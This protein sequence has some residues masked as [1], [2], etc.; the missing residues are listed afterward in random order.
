MTAR[1]EARLG[2]AADLRVCEPAHAAQLHSL[3]ASLG[4]GLHRRD[5]RKLGGGTAA[6]FARALAA[7]VGVIDFDGPRQ[8]LAATALEYYL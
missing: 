3:R 4:T 2:I 6:A 5:E 8:R 1:G 7:E